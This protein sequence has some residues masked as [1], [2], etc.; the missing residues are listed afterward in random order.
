ML[1][2]EKQ[3]Y[4]YTEEVGEVPVE[5]GQCTVC[6][7]KLWET[8]HFFYTYDDEGTETDFICNKC[9]TKKGSKHY[10][11]LSQGCPKTNE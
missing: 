5:I 2:N 3:N 7:K 4:G 8:D 11:R 9:Y 10:D 6:L 1:E